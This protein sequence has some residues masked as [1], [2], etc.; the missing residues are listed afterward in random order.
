MT[1]SDHSQN[2]QR[3]IRS[4]VFVALALLPREPRLDDR[5]APHLSYPYPYTTPTKSF[6]SFV[7]GE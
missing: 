2:G 1:Q 7:E 3:I 5:L 4:S 6:A